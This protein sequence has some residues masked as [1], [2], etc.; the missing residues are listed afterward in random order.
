[1]N[2]SKELQWQKKVLRDFRKKSPSKIKIENEKIFKKYLKNH[3]N[4]FNENLKFPTE[5]FKNKKV[6][7]LGCG[8]GEVDIVLNSFGAKCFGYDFN[9]KSIDRANFLKKK[10]RIKNIF[11]KKKN[12]E[13]LKKEKLAQKLRE[14]LK[15]RKKIKK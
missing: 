8:T 12:I 5:L 13:D 3:L 14:N 10:F 7:D 11:F 6:L 4:L 9:E 1:M 2:N 15:K